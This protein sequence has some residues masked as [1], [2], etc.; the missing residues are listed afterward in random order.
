MKRTLGFV[1]FLFVM[2]VS[3]TA[4]GFGKGDR[5]LALWEDAFWYPGTVTAVQGNVLTITFDDGDKA[6]VDAERVE[7]LDWAAGDRV[8]CRWPGDGKNYPGV[9]TEVKG[10]NVRIVY[11]DGDKAE[12]HV[13]KC[14]QSRQSRLV[15][16]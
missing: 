14:R 16:R 9:F 10:E 13:G 4:F 11:D 1:V 12:L 8:E 15:G 6:T 3:V 2:F 7:K 5:V